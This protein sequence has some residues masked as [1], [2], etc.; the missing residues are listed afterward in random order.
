[1]LAAQSILGDTN[2]YFYFYFLKKKKSEKEVSR[3]MAEMMPREMAKIRSQSV[4]DEED[5]FIEED[6]SVDWA[7]SP[8]YD[9]YL[10]EEVSSIHQVPFES[11]KQEVF[12]LKVDFLGVDVIL[13]K[14]F[15][16]SIDKIYGAESTFLSKS[17]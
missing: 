15:N 1:L 6:C 16:Q 14:T 13:S 10:D 11:P 9:T 8:I 4:V 2:F 17:E 3:K 7:S 5:G 12:D